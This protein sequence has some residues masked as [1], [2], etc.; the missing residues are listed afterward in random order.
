MTPCDLTIIPRRHLPSANP[1]IA[2]RLRLRLLRVPLWSPD[3]GLKAEPWPKRTATRMSRMIGTLASVL[4][5]SIGSDGPKRQPCLD[6][7]GRLTSAAHCCR[8]RPLDVSRVIWAADEYRK[9]RAGTPFPIG[10]QSQ[11]LDGRSMPKFQ[12][13]C[14]L[15][16]NACTKP[17]PF[18]SQFVCRSSGSAQKAGS[19]LP[20]LAPQEPISWLQSQ[21]PAR[22]ARAQGTRAD[23][24]LAC[25]VSRSANIFLH[26]FVF[27]LQ[28]DRRSQGYFPLSGQ[29]W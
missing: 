20:R 5:P 21:G 7:S 14:C 18:R 15:D 4:A 19:F 8:C 26:Y 10:P 6:S 29:D 27:F 2:F 28:H 11:G 1:T 23:S 17:N 22:L 24:C 16:R 9:G 13:P 12:H 3:L 25:R